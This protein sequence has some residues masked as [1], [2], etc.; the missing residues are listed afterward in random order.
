MTLKSSNP[1]TI[2]PPQARYSHSVEVPAGARWL[3]ISGQVG[4]DKDGIIP[5]GVTEQSENCWK[6]VIAILEDAGMTPDDLVR[7]NSYITDS[8]Y[9]EGWRN[10]R[11]KVLVT[12]HLPASTLSVVVGLAS[13]N[14]FVEVEAVAAKVD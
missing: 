10:G 7:V 12:D 6:N 13:P 1:S 9:V 8:R 5:T 3:Y 4:T 11:D 14:I 2:A